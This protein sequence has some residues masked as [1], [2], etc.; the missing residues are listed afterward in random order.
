MDYVSIIQAVTR[1]LVALIL[2]G[3]SIYLLASGVSLPDYY[4]YA[5]ALV[6]GGLFGVEAV[7]KMFR[8]KNDK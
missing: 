5:V 7:A 1:A 3:G 4:W 2:A 8:V 6:L